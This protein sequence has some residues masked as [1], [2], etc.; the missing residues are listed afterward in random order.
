MNGGRILKKNIDCLF[1]GDAIFDVTVILQKT[2]NPIVSGGTVNSKYISIS[3]GGIG[4]VAVTLSKLGGKA[5]QCGVIGNEL[6]GD[7]Y[8]QDLQ[9][10][11]GHTNSF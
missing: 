2:R 10:K 6:L 4:N 7:M 11:K 5:A 8:R 1:L 3:P 9:K